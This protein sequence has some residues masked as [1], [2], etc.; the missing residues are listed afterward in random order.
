MTQPDPSRLLDRI[1]LTVPR[2]GFYDAPDPSPFEPVISPKPGTH[3]CVFAFYKRWLQG[4][5]LHITAD[6]AGCG[7]AGHWLCNVEGR[8]RQEYIEFLADEEGLRAS[9]DLMNRWLEATR[10]YQQQYPNLLIGP[11]KV[12]QYPYLKTVTFL[13]N[14]DQLSLLVIGA[15]YDSGPDDPSSVIVPFGS[16][17]LELVPLFDDLKIPQAMIGATDIAMRQYLPPELLAFTVTK[18][19]LERL[20]R[21]D[22]RSFLYKPFRER[23]RKARGLPPD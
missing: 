11:L 2:I 20:C 9:H 10:P 5:T 6:N 14:P 23:L 16:G 19:M 21:L 18:P 15:Y 1:D 7:G 22:E 4:Q 8:S 12:D 17:C 3:A 13:V